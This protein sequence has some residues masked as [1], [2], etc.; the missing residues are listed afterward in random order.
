MTNADW[1]L[2]NETMK[3]LRAMLVR[4]AGLFR[5]KQ[6]E[7]EMNEEL[8]MNARYTLSRP[9]ARVGQIATRRRALPS[10]HLICVPARHTFRRMAI[11]TKP[12]KTPKGERLVARI[13]PEDKAIIAKA[14]AIAGQSVGSFV[15]A[16]ARK[17]ALDTLET[18]ER[19]ILS[20]AQSRR[21]VEMLLAPVRSPNA[22]LAD[23]L[24][25]YRV[26]VKSDLD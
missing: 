18:Q 25:L 5:R 8:R 15:L 20:G 24:R 2:P 4:F 23:A 12:R 9:F 14:A 17:A 6:H 10:Q 7:V 16:Q 22:A 21:F 26:K 1:R 3:T 19:V 13:S 11:L